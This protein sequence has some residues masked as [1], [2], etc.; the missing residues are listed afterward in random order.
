MQ[1]S[2]FQ[3]KFADLEL[4][5]VQIEQLMGYKVGESHEA[6]SE[7]TDKLLKEAGTICNIK[8][9]FRIFPLVS[10]V[11]PEKSIEINGF[12]FN[13]KKIVYGQLKRAESIAVFLC[14]AGPEIGIRSRTAMN[15]GDLLTGYI[16]DVIGSAIAEGAADLMQGNLQE[17]VS[18]ESKKITN[19][20]SP[21]YCG[22]DVAEQH[23][24]FQLMR[25]N[26][27]GIKLNDSA[28]MNPEKSVSGFIG[29]GGHVRYN[30]YTCGLCDMKDCIYR[31]I[32]V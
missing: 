20:Y 8:A 14:T 2:A 21:G 19:R 27:C 11:D 1:N 12:I 28:L 10:F 3:F 15:D 17:A 29:I 26:Y 9:E 30:P 6:I 16:Y 13:V 18:A 5:V 23:K 22:W 31:N 32:K 7:L 24:L 4:D 25:D